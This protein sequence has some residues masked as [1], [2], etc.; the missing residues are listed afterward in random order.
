M[1]K[2][3]QLSISPENYNTDNVERLI[4]LH[5]GIKDDNLHYFIQKESLDCRWRPIYN[6]N[7][8]VSDCNDLEMSETAP[9][10]DVSKAD[11]TVAVIGAGPC[12]L[13]AALKL[14]QYGIKPIIIERGAPVE[15]RKKDIAQIYRSGIVNKNS[16]YCFGEGGA[17]TF[18]D[19]KLYT[20]SNKKGDVR[21]VLNLLVHFG[22]SDKILY[23]SHPHIGTDILSKIIKNIRNT[24]E[25]YGGKYLFNTN[26]TDFLVKDGCAEGVITSAGDKILADRIILAAGHSAKNI[27]QLFYERGWAIE[28]KPFAM[29][30]RVEHPQQL[31]NKI[32]YKGNVIAELPPA[33]YSLAYTFN[34]RGVYSFCMCPGGIVIP[35]Q[36]TDGIMVVNGMSNSKRNGKFAN[37]AIVVSVNVNDVPEYSK[38]GSLSLLRFQQACERN[39]FVERQLC[40][41]QRITDFVEGRVSQSLATTSYKPGLVSSN[42]NELLPKFISR[43]LKSGF[44]YFNTKMKGFITDEANIIGLESRTSS[45]V[46]IVRDIHTLEHMSL[47]KL[48]P[49]GE[50]AGYSGGITSCCREDIRKFCLVCYL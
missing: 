14:I 24:I 4:R 12:G 38:Y 3:I 23:Q 44:G 34:N 26:V 42:M 46:R 36:E 17:G 5:T 48:Y 49:C 28:A 45:P 39:M 20:R 7:I 37:S 41:A 2:N 27:Y 40:P 16:N 31:I 22:A 1:K 25:E 29:G 35:T 10:R 43:H 30:V 47:K 32:Q 18:S 50:G 33:E 13:M 21:E 19:G 8:T 15:Q 9:F 6:L 11:R